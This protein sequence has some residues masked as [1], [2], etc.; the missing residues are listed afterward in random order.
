MIEDLVVQDDLFRLIIVS[1]NGFYLVGNK[2][3]ARRMVSY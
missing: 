3:L 1:S 2:S